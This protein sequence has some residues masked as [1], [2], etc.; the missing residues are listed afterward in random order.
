MGNGTLLPISAVDPRSTFCR[1]TGRKCAC[2]ARILIAAS[3]LLTTAA[4]PAFAGPLEDA[5]RAYAQQDFAT[6]LKLLRPLASNGNAQA[7][8]ALGLMYNNGQGV[9][10]DFAAA[11]RWWQLAA[12]QGNALA[13]VNLGLA[14]GVNQEFGRAYT[15]LS[16]AAAQGFPNAKIFR[17]TFAERMTQEQ[18]TEAHAEAQRC[19]ASNYKLCE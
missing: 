11:M 15:W 5:K 16:A 10:Q 3:L 6:A 9:A 2:L 8:A 17:T 18:I 14:Y 1:R 4:G 7:Q 13:Q 12:A 19:Q